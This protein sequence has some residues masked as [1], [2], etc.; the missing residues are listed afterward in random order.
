MKLTPEERK[1]VEI[2]Q[3]MYKSFQ[4]NVSDSRKLSEAL[5]LLRQFPNDVTDELTALCI[6]WDERGMEAS[7]YADELSETYDKL[8]TT[9][10]QNIISLEENDT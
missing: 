10:H 7:R 4:R 5:K 3:A 1:I 6:R 9:L 8:F 2:N